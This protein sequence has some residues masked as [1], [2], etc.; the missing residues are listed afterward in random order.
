MFN[1][2][3]SAV[4]G[5]R[6]DRE[7]KRIKPILAEI[8]VHGERLRSVNDDELRA[9]TQKLRGIIA[10]RTQALSTQIAELKERKRTAAEA[11]ERESIDNQL[12]GVDGRG[13]LEGE[14]RRTIRDTLDELL[15]EAFATVRE[16]ARRL[17]GTQGMVAGREVGRNM[18]H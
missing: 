9:Q 14:Y 7:L 2:L 12:M 8:E 17:V 1:K 10:E 6:H 13:G 18:G 4:F 3:L 5:S 11:S 15:P 16:T